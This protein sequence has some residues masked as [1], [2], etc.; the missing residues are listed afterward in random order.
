MKA[1]WIGIVIVVV[2]VVGA[3]AGYGGYTLGMKAGQARAFSARNAFMQARGLNT[4]R[5]GGQAGTS[6]AFNPNNF[7][8]GEIKQVDG[9]TIQLSTAQE[10]LTVKLTDQTQIQ[11]MAT[12]TVSDLQVGE[13]ISVQGERAADGTLTARSIQIGGGFVPGVGLGTPPAGDQ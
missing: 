13:R 9:D 4:G 8:S 12:G 5:P 10:V 7:A 11:K 1:K 2:L 3:A 6:A